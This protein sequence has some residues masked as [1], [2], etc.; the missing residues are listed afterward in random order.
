M[1]KKVLGYVPKIGIPAL[2]GMLV[3]R[4]VRARRVPRKRRFLARVVPHH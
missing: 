4:F 3:A 1:L 2:V